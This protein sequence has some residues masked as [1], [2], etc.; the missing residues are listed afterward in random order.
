[1]KIGIIGA[2]NSHTASI[3]KVVNV[4]KRIRGAQVTHVWGETRAFA[5][6]AAEVGQIPQIIKNPAEL[7]GQVDGAVVDHR[8]GKLHLPAAKALLEARVPLFIDKPFCYRL[9]EGRRFLARAAEL[10]VP[11][12]SFSTLPKQETFRTLQKEA[13]QLGRID[14]VITS[15]PCDIKSKWGGIFFYG[16][17]QVDMIL[18]LLGYELG[19]AQVV[20][21][22]GKNHEAVLSFASGALGVMNLIG[23]GGAQFHVSVI[24]E[25]GRLDRAI[26]Y[27]QS[28]YLTGV[29]EFTGMFKSGKSPET[30]QSMLAPVAALEALEKSVAT[31]RRVKV[32]SI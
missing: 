2:E 10:K 12:C 22:A 21:G 28:P 29:R 26:T 13:R 31:G 19:Y 20:K 4:E 6:K 1:M 18:R 9:A 8:H 7:I 23:A 32:S 17:H 24:G 3:A 25:K 16:I 11:V 15:G 27:D 14:A 30:L 5:L